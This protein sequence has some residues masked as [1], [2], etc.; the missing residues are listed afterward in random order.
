MPAFLLHKLVTKEATANTVHKVHITLAAL[1]VISSS[2]TLSGLAAEALA[3]EEISLLAWRF[4]SLELANGIGNIALHSMELNDIPVNESFKLLIE[5]SDLAVG[6]GFSYQL[7]N[8]TY[9]VVDKGVVLTKGGVD[10]IKKFVS[11]VDMNYTYLRLK[12]LS[13]S[14]NT[15]AKQA[16]LK[17][18]TQIRAL[19]KYAREYL[20]KKSYSFDP[21]IVFINKISTTEAGVLKY[22]NLREFFYANIPGN[23][24]SIFIENFTIVPDDVLS[25][26]NK[27]VSLIEEWKVLATVA[28]REAFVKTLIS[29]SGKN[30]WVAWVNSGRPIVPELATS[31]LEHI[32]HGEIRIKFK[33]GITPDF[34]ATPEK[35]WAE[36]Q[37]KFMS[38]NVF[39]EALLKTDNLGQQL[40]TGLHS[41]DEIEK[42]SKIALPN[43]EKLLTYSSKNP[44]I[45]L[46]N[47]KNAYEVLN[48]L[49]YIP[50][51]NNLKAIN[52]GKS[53]N[54][55]VWTNVGRTIN[56]KLDISTCYFEGMSKNA[57]AKMISESFVLKTN[58][59]GSLWGSNMNYLNTSFQIETRINDNI[60][61]TS[62]VKK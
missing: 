19:A 5:V 56:K 8:G 61:S 20:L 33:D 24:R 29:N 51:L 21:Q 53:L 45:T 25:L 52:N 50:D 48:P 18:L 62:Y 44:I 43:G 9:K 58:K 59:S 57:V 23:L 31:T 37:A 49:V 4:H 38:D 34:I 35:I 39:A 12:V 27:D 54:N 60:I 42:L 46:V 17:S 2:G 22:P 36:L 26:L 28:E 3:E 32:Y 55:R 41:F 13:T 6:L 47:G 30:A 40:F 15:A 1:M 7:V 16:A 14:A 10:A 11:T